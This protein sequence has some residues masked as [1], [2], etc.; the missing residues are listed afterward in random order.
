MVCEVG[1]FLIIDP[2]SAGGN[3]NESFNVVA[4]GAEGQEEHGEIKAKRK[5]E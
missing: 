5:Q 2:I 3:L 4:L 1:M